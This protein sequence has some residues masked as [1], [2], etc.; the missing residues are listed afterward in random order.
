MACSSLAMGPIW[1]KF[2]I[3]HHLTPLAMCQSSKIENSIAQ[4]KSQVQKLQNVV[5]SNWPTWKQGQRAYEMCNTTIGLTLTGRKHQ[6]DICT[7][8]T[9]SIWYPNL[10]VP[11]SAN[12]RIGKKVNQIPK[13]GKNVKIFKKSICTFKICILQALK[14]P[15]P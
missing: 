15:F 8:N 5:F 2:N 3:N 4:K 11:I 13:N 6:S 7:W 14:S 1:V 10:N 9:F 12:I